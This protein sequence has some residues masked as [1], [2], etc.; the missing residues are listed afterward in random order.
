M[1]K[2][3]FVTGISSG[4]GK[5]FAEQIVKNGDILV[6]TMRNPAQIAEFNAR[7]SGKA[8]AVK[9]DVTNEAEVKAAIDAAVAEHGRIDVLVN[10]AGY[11]VLGAVEELSPDEI[12]AQFETNVMGVIHATQAVL[13][14]MR[15]VKSGSIVQMSSVVGISSGPGLGAYSASKFAV[16]GFSETLASEVNPLGIK[17]MIVEP[18]P[19][20]TNFSNRSVVRRAARRIT[21]YAATAHERIERVIGL[22]GKQEGD[23]VKAVQLIMKALDSKNPPLRL[24]LGR[25]AIDRIRQKIAE[26]ARDITAWEKPSLDT[27]R[28]DVNG[29]ATIEADH[30]HAG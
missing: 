6:G 30:P 3:W 19:F 26:I 1:N 29:S 17:V 9:V 14:H 13:P 10:N 24:A 5:A 11:G 20:R 2:V 7:Y 16:E 23:P 28:N 4:F 12:R 27:V 18:G 8:K 21:D 22:D 15:K 25:T